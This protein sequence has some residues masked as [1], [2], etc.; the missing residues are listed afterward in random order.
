MNLR[1]SSAMS[2][3]V[4]HHMSQKVKLEECHRQV[5]YRMGMH[6]LFLRQQELTGEQVNMLISKDVS[7]LG[8]IKW[9]IQ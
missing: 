1:T 4:G 9:A 6:T 8:N 3:A 7:L 5:K 2:P